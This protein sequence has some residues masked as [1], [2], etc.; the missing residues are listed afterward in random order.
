MSIEISL[1][2]R[3]RGIQFHIKDGK[4]WQVGEK[5][6]L[7][8]PVYSGGGVFKQYLVHEHITPEGDDVVLNE[9]INAC[10]Q[11]NR[12]GGHQYITEAFRDGS[13]VLGYIML[14]RGSKIS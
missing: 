4:D 13:G 9:L 2:D 3:H 10:S 1:T 5:Q 8:T 6:E 14:K 12:G 11:I 7:E